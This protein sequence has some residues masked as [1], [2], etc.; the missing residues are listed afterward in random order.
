MDLVAFRSRIALSVTPITVLFALGG[1][2]AGGAEADTPSEK[3]AAGQASVSAAAPSAGGGGDTGVTPASAGEA[4]V[5]VDG[6]TLTFP[7]LGACDMDAD[8]GFNFNF[9]A[10]DQLSDIRAGGYEADGAWLGSINIVYADGAAYQAN[11]DA[12]GARLAIDGDGMTLSGPMLYLPR[13]DGSL[14][15]PQ[16]IGQGTIAATCP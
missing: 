15:T 12:D 9:I 4:I 10:A 2:G 3:A 8:G 7:T 14:P 16:P 6:K 1:C 13:N 5:V 11:L